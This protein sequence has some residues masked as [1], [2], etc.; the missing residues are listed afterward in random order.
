MLDK[1]NHDGAV[2]RTLPAFTV[3]SSAPVT[4]EW[5]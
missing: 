3:C 1:R 4:P 2:G 5:R